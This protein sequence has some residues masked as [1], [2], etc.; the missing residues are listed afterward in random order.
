MAK[1]DILLECLS[2]NFNRSVSTFYY[3]CLFLLM[4]L[5]FLANLIAFHICWSPPLII[6]MYVCVYIYVYVYIYIYSRICVCFDYTVVSLS[7]SVVSTRQVFWS[8]IIYILC[9]LSEHRLACDCTFLK[10]KEKK[11]FPLT[12]AQGLSNFLSGVLV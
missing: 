11:T 8:H 6:N 7:R 10:E 1:G 4:M 3:L 2:G 9:C 5:C 12:S